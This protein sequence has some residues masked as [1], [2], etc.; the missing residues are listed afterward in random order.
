MAPPRVHVEANIQIYQ[1][2]GEAGVTQAK[3]HFADKSE[4][5][6]ASGGLQHLQL[7]E[8]AENLENLN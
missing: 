2:P 5:R 6:T 3:G 4:A 8:K 7:Q 1:V